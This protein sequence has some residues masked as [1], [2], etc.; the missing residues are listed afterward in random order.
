MFRNINHANHHAWLGEALAALRW[1]SLLL[2]AGAGELKN[3]VHY[4]HL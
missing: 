1:G 4:K 2:D 3:R